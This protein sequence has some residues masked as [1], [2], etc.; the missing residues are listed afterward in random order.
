MAVAPMTIINPITGAEEPYF[1]KRRRIHRILA[2][3]M[4]IIMMVRSQGLE[5]HLTTV[6]WGSGTWWDGIRLG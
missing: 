2:G 4:V 3:S 1:P 5:Q 6:S